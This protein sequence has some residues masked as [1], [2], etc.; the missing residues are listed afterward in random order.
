MTPESIFELQLIDCNCNDCK[1]MERDLEKYKKSSEFHYKLQLDD[2]EREKKRLN[3]I[4]NQWY[5]IGGL[6]EGFANEI[7]LNR[8]KFQFNK[9][10]INYGY[11]SKLNKSVTFIP[12]ICQPDT[13]QCFIHRKN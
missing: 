5:R 7:V 1:F 8:M 10:P 2:F 11:C 9:P 13:Q 6:E 3:D 4:T 12:K